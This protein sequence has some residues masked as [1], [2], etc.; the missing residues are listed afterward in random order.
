MCPVQFVTYVSGRSNDLASHLGV[1]LSLSSHLGPV[2][3]PVIPLR[4][5]HE[6]NVCSFHR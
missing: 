2:D 1:S 3:R 6:N 5:R 4:S